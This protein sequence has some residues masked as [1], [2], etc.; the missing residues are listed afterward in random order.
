MLEK[1]IKKKRLNNN[2]Y[3]LHNYYVETKF[4]SR[5]KFLY[6]QLSK[7]ILNCEELNKIVNEKLLIQMNKEKTI[8]NKILCDLHLK[9]NFEKMEPLRNEGSEFFGDYDDYNENYSIF[10]QKNYDS[11]YNI[12]N[13]FL[14]PKIK[15]NF[16]LINIHKKNLFY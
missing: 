11:F 10:E 9:N 14:T 4:M 15:N 2:N 16:E 3:L 5:N 12:N 8:S 7:L 1:Y 13:D 6:Y